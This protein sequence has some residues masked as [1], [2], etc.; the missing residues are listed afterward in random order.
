MAEYSA[1]YVVCPYYRRLNG[2]RICCEGTDKTNTINVVFEDEKL[3]KEYEAR[4]CN[5][6]KGHK[7]CLVCR[8]LYSKY[9]PL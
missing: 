6:I 8:A 5:D 9:Y 7:Q 1:K 2:N 4:Y 3:L